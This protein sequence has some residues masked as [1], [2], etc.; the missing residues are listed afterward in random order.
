MISTKFF[1]LSCNY[2]IF[3]VGKESLKFSLEYQFEFHT[4]P[5]L[6]SIIP[7]A[8]LLSVLVR[9]PGR[10]PSSSVRLIYY[11][12]FLLVTSL[13]GFNSTIPTGG[14]LAPASWI[15][16]IRNGQPLC[17]SRIGFGTNRTDGQSV[18]GIRWSI[19]VSES[20]K[21]FPLMGCGSGQRPVHPFARKQF[22]SIILVSCD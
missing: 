8:Y 5:F 2:Y 12:L 1:Y 17:L 21:R 10:V 4:H 3:D 14:N 16:S 13:R 20:K 9:C 6:C 18:V 15:S 11:Y 7:V 22:G 19:S